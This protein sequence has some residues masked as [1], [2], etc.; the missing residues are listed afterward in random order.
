MHR[1]IAFLCSGQGGQHPGMFDLFADC[2]ECEP[3][4]A[5]ASRQL[6]Q[7]PRRFVREADREAMFADREAQILCC[8]H[9]LV[10]WAGLASARPE[11]VVIAGYSVGELAAWGCAGALDTE[12]TLRLT[13]RRAII[14]EAIAPPDGGL[15]GIVGLTR[16]V[17]DPI[18][19]RH[20]TSIAIINDTDS[21]VIG[22]HAAALEASC[23]DALANG[24]TRAHRIPVAV[25]SHTSLLAQAVE[26]F[27]LALRE[28]TPRQPQ[29]M[30]RL[31]SG[32]DGDA[33]HNVE[34]G[35]DKL[36]RQIC[37]PVDWM[38]CLESC[39]EAEAVRALELGPGT[40]LSRMAA[41]YFSS[42]SVRSTDEFRTMLG[43]RTW[44]SRD[45]D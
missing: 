4:F 13:H 44:L 43:L 34:M 32:I 30:Y 31:L 26:P 24:A 9:A 28:A 3:V 22:G 8:T 41:P 27:R 23:Q 2:A 11:R 35:C 38:A 5:A 17:L 7:D 45:G 12:A 33:V 10:A 20:G 1:P 29:I 16:T 15:A 39:R 19:L 36:A 42:D 37:T 6:G 14:M 25:P 21:F 40:A 18:L